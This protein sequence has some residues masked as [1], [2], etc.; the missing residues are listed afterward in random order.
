VITGTSPNLDLAAGVDAI[1]EAVAQ[2]LELHS[3]ERIEILLREMES[4][5]S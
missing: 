2:S 3:A 4:A 1:T 5:S